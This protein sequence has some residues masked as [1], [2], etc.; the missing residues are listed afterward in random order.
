MKPLLLI[1]MCFPGI[2]RVM[3]NT[4]A[5]LLMVFLTAAICQAGTI[6]SSTLIQPD[7]YRVKCSNHITSTCQYKKEIQNE[8]GFSQWACRSKHKCTR[9]FYTVTDDVLKP[10][11][12][13]SGNTKQFLSLDYANTWIGSSV[14]Q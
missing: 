3:L 8:P 5:A 6:K 12:T 13:I 1:N 11:H 7:R 2:N 10:V 14:C 4:V 9:N